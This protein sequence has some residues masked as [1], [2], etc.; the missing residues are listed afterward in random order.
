MLSGYFSMLRMSGLEPLE[1]QSLSNALFGAYTRRFE[2]QL[3]SEAEIY[4][5][6]VLANRAV[7]NSLALDAYPWNIYARTDMASSLKLIR[8]TC[9]ALGDQVLRVASEL[10]L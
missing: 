8:Y 1:V 2:N 3:E 10:S 5:N 7:E 6:S 9:P 4:L